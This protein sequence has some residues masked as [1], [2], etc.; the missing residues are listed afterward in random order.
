MNFVDVDELEESIRH[1]QSRERLVDLYMMGNPS[2]ANWPNFQNYVIAMLPQ[3][4]TLDGTEITKSMRIIA[5][6]HLAEYEV[7]CSALMVFS[8]TLHKSSYICSIWSI[9]WSFV[10][11]LLRSDRRLRPRNLQLHASKL[12]RKEC[13]K[14]GPMGSTSRKSRRCQRGKK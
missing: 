5:K 10:L 12:R 8:Q 6:Q 1:L 3:L 2:Q 13:M 9:R 14:L 11:S 7:S 4:V